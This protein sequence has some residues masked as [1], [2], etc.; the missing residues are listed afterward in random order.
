MRPDEGGHAAY[1]NAAGCRITFRSDFS[2]TFVMLHGWGL[3]CLRAGGQH[4][5]YVTKGCKEIHPTRCHGKHEWLPRKHHGTPPVPT[6]RNASSATA[7]ATIDDSSFGRR[8]VH[9]LT[10]RAVP[11]ERLRHLPVGSPLP[12]VCSSPLRVSAFSYV[13]DEV[14]IVADWI[15]YHASLFGGYERLHIVDN[16]ST[17]GTLDVLHHLASTYGIKLYTAKD[18]RLKGHAMT[19]LMRT[20][21][22]V[23]DFVMPLDI[24][25]FLVLTDGDE[26]FSPDSKVRAP[27]HISIEGVCAYL[28]GM[29]KGYSA[30]KV[31]RMQPAVV[32]EGGFHDAVREA[33]LARHE[34]G[35]LGKWR[36]AKTFFSTR[37][38]IPKVDQGFHMGSLATSALFTKLSLVHYHTR[39]AEQLKQKT[40]HNWLGL[41]LPSTSRRYSALHHHL[42]AHTIRGQY[43]SCYRM[44]LYLCMLRTTQ[45]M[46]TISLEP[47]RAHMMHARGGQA[48]ITTA[49][50]GHLFA[51]LRRYSRAAPAAQMPGLWPSPCYPTHRPRHCQPHTR[52]PL[53]LPSLTT[54]GV[55]KGRQREAT[56]RRMLPGGLARRITLTDATMIGLRGSCPSL[57]RHAAGSKRAGR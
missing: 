40:L 25:E 1:A 20:H 3:S 21:A 33:T 34:R 41:G 14:D 32:S 53:D 36:I 17:D 2:P 38:A 44:A 35:V 57:P 30:Y 54:T 16:N 9:A 46:D 8:T 5:L 31:N 51:F 55:Q 12:R 13:R 18:F 43:Y 29:N 19:H 56:T 42:R 22:N 37:R 52:R 28:E 50:K 45:P 6:M 23:S 10:P 27:T 7:P 15:H 24:D 11:P 4:H 48:T 49:S 39:S 47:L 26:G